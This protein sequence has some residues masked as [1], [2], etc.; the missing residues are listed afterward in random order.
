MHRASCDIKSQ[1]VTKRKGR[2]R[3]VGRK[4]NADVRYFLKNT[5]I[6]SPWTCDLKAARRGVARQQYKFNRAKT[7]GDDEYVVGLHSHATLTISR[8]IDF[9]FNFSTLHFTIFLMSRA[10]A[11]ASSSRAVN[12]VLGDIFAVWCVFVYWWCA[13]MCI[14]MCYF[15][16][17]LCIKLTEHIYNIISDRL[18]HQPLQET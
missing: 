6:I 9:K 10:T 17:R 3:W 5:F 18:V 15:S 1:F 8:I 13:C 11:F 16:V 4:A 14:Y 12:Y 2:G 7:V